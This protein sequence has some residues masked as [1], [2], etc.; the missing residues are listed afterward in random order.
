M[1]TFSVEAGARWDAR[2]LER[3]L[4]EF[5]PWMV[6]RARGSWLVQGS[7]GVRSIEDV[8]PLVEL[9]ARERG[10]DPLLVLLAA[11]LPPADG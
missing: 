5:S 4:S 9:W 6:E 3:L 1:T 8:R 11:D 7:L 10:K 2:D